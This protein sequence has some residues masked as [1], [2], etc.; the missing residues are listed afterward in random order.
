MTETTETPSSTCSR[1]ARSQA[2]LEDQLTI[3]GFLS[4]SRTKQIREPPSTTWYGGRSGSM[5][6]P[7]SCASVPSRSSTPM[8]M[9][10]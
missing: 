6:C 8:A 10:P 1:A 9:C 7:A 3:V 5:P 2:S 4:G